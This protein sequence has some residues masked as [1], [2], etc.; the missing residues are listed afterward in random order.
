M[1][2]QIIEAPRLAQPDIAPS[3]RRAARLTGFG[4]LAIFVLAIFANFFVREGLVVPGDAATTFANI[5]ESETLFRFGLL[6]FLAVF[7]LDVAI[8]W[9]LHLVFQPV[10]RQVSL[11]AAWFRL[12]YTVFLGVA[13]VFFFMALELVGDAGHL[14]AFTQGQ[15]EAQVTFAV[16]AFNFTWLIGL[17]AFGFH[18][19]LI[20]YLMIRSTVVSRLL[21]AFVA[22]AGAAYVADTTAYTLL[23]NYDDYA[24]AFLEMVAVPSVIGELWF[25]IWLLRGGLGRRTNG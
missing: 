21:A 12:V 4:Y 17:V 2:S 5:A 1:T 6:A 10:S 15:L 9:G 8:T 3:P 18:L 7:I 19:A 14:S 11:V 25:T 22:L 20:S 23:A 16:N 13:A 24:N